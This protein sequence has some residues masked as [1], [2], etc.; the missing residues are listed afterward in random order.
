MSLV[1]LQNFTT[2]FSPLLPQA[3]LYEKGSAMLYRGVANPDQITA[4]GCHRYDSWY[5]RV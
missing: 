2:F 5:A 1:P 3:T 4:V